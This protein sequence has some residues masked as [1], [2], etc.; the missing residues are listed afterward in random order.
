MAIM[1][2]ADVTLRIGN[3][4]GI[5]D[6]PKDTA[7]KL[8]TSHIGWFCKIPQLV[9]RRHQQLDTLVEQNVED[10]Q[11]VINMLVPQLLATEDEGLKRELAA[12][13]NVTCSYLI[14][15]NALM[16]LIALDYFNRYRLHL[17]RD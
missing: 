10:Y 2:A 17:T 16:G 6:F 15:A 8:K 7:P 13:Y 1:N 12:L 3:Y 11:L 14:E 9:D 5:I 4:L